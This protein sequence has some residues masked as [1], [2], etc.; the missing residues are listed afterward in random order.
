VVGFNSLRTGSL[1]A[2]LTKIRFSHYQ[3]PAAN[4][5]VW[6]DISAKINLCVATST[7]WQGKLVFLVIFPKFYSCFSLLKVSNRSMRGLPK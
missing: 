3:S 4:H 2:G 5:S 7:V 1:T 6:P